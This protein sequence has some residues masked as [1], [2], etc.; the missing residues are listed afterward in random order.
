M[1]N[2][3]S[4]RLLQGLLDGGN[5]AVNAVDRSFVPNAKQA[6]S[7]SVTADIVGRLRRDEVL[8]KDGF[9]AVDG[10]DQRLPFV[11]LQNTFDGDDM[12]EGMQSLAGHDEIKYG[13]ENMDEI[14]ASLLARY[15][16]GELNPVD[17]P[18]RTMERYDVPISVGTSN[19]RL[20]DDPYVDNSSLEALDL[21]DRFLPDDMEIDDT[22]RFVE[23]LGDVVRGLD[24]NVT[25]H[26]F[27]HASQG[28][29]GRDRLETVRDADGDYSGQEKGISH[30]WEDHPEYA[31]FVDDDPEMAKSL[32]LHDVKESFPDAQ[33][34]GRELNQVDHAADFDEMIPIMRDLKYSNYYGQ[35]GGFDGVQ[36]M[37]PQM[38]RPSI[39][40]GVDRQMAMEERDFGKIMHDAMTSV[41]DR[42]GSQVMEMSPQTSRT[43]QVQ[44]ALSEMG[45]NESVSDREGY[46]NVLRRI[47]A[48]Y[49]MMDEP[50]QARMAKLF[51][52]LGISPVV[53][54]G[55]G[56]QD[57][58]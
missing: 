22:E 52:M 41:L 47:A 26:E 1:P 9:R 10:A 42:P 27:N 32:Y 6:A 30:W 58:Y 50:R 29:F 13:A 43:R 5:D 40:L 11:K 8:A 54:A 36:H 37:A 28:A 48:N 46:Y 14:R 23:S 57:G 7:D 31:D 51:A 24:E 56:E 16:D 45:V 35:R 19:L 44:D 15:G 18:S 39:D 3:R 2:R 53:L 21:S 12:V 20:A 49:H 17:M 34:T 33:F 4:L 38:R 55:Q 25:S